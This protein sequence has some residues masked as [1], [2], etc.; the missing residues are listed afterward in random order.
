MKLLN[1]QKALAYG[2]DNRHFVKVGVN[3]YDLHYIERLVTGR[4]NF[5]ELKVNEITNSFSSG[6]SYYYINDNGASD[7]ALRDPKKISKKFYKKNLKSYMI[8]KPTI[9]SSL[10]KYNFNKR[11]IIAAMIEFNKSYNQY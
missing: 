4:I 7:P 3:S 10:D 5:Y 8:D 2:F 6:V 9:W 1:P 11:I